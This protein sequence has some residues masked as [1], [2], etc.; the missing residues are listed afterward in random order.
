M[1][2]SVKTGISFGLTSAVITTLGLMVGLTSG[3]RSEEVVIGG[4]LTI[5]LADAFSDSLG[6]HISEEAEG[7]HTPKEIWLATVSTFCSKLGVGSMFI[8]PIL[9]LSLDMAAIINIVWGFFLLG[10]FSFY[11][12]SLKEGNPWN[13]VFEHLL[14]ATIVIVAAHFLGSWVSN[15]LNS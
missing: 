2:H 3:T 14:T 8:V 6:I 15:I 11:V 13:V 5:A 9:F 10:G 7:K 12:G 4:V 1:R